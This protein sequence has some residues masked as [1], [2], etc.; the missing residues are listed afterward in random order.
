MVTVGYT[1]SRQRPRPLNLKLSPLNPQVEIHLKLAGASNTS[2]GPDGL[3]YRHLRALD[4]AGF[5]LEKIYSKVWC[6]GIPKAWK[7]SRTVLIH[8]KGDTNDIANFR[9]ISL[10]SML[11]KIFSGIISQKLTTTAVDL[12]WISPEQKRFLPGVQGIQE[13]TQLLTA[14]VEEAKTERRDLSISWLDLSNAFGFVPHLVISELF[15]S[16]PLP[17]ALCIRLRDIYEDNILNFAIGRESL[18]IIPS[19]GVRQGD[20][21]S[22]MVFNLVMEPLI[23]LVTSNANPGFNLFGTSV[24]S[25][26][27]ADDIS[28]VSSLGDQ[29]LLDTLVGTAARLG[30]RFNGKKCC[31]LSFRKG[32]LSSEPLIINDE[33]IRCLGEDDQ[34]PY[35]GV[36]IGAKLLF[37]PPT[38]M[39][40]L[41]DKIRDSGLAPYQKLEVYR[42]HL[43]PSL[44][45]HLA[46]GQ[47]I[48]A[49]LDQLDIACRKF[50]KSIADLPYRTTDAFFYADRRIGGLGTFRLSDDAD[51]WTIARA[52]QLLTSRDTTVSAIFREQLKNT[53]RRSLNDIVPDPLPL[54]PYL[55][56]SLEDGLYRVPDGPAGLNLWTLTRKA[57]KR[58]GAQIDVSSDFEI[59][60]IADDISVP[61]KKAVR[62]LRTA[63]RQ[64]WSK[65]LLEAPHQGR[66]A[67]GLD[68]DSSKDMAKILSCRTG[69]KIID[70][71]TVL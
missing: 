12:N 21:L 10:L 29:A 15:D 33:A 47:C 11:Y 20:A 17:P 19:A 24:K 8:K 49:V 46:S 5:L 27:Y 25:T 59:T 44:S 3:E 67:K 14:A 51:I 30:L 70:W 53:I 34:E 39:V 68:L 23:R 2:A 62:G 13:H 71:C 55:S 1:A 56:G 37:R 57:A 43:L 63:V 65:R 32:K 54:G 69:L 52:T 38:S 28:I 18:P 42:A 16:L 64:H 9:P 6:L 7:A 4:P 31:N 40:L 61:P 41:M 35:L 22:P 45:H 26:V 66:V 50:L 36:P 58:I 48:K 60:I